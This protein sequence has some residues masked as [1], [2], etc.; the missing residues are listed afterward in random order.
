MLPSVL[1]GSG[2]TAAVL[3]FSLLVVAYF[4][5]LFAFR[6]V[7]GLG[8]AADALQTWGARS[9]AKRRSGIERRLGIR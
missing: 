7:G 9:A 2:Y 1:R 5:L 3:E 6:L 4:V 8:R